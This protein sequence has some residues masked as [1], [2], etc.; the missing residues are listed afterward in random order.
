[1]PF[2]PLWHLDTHVLVS[3]RLET[4]PAPGQLD[5][6]APFSHADEWRLK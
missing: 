1:M 2:I 6:L 3:D 4:R 5:P